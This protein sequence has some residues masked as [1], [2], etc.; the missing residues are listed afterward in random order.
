MKKLLIL[1][2]ALLSVAILYGAEKTDTEKRNL[3]GKVKSVELKAQPKTSIP[4]KNG[5]NELVRGN[6]KEIEETNVCAGKT[7][8]NNFLFNEK[9]QITGMELTSLNGNVK[10]SIKMEYNTD[11]TISQRTFNKR[12][13]NDSQNLLGPKNE[14]NE[15]SIDEQPFRKNIDLSSREGGDGTEITTYFYKNGKLFKT[16][17]EI[18]PNTH[19]E[20]LYYPNGDI[21]KITEKRGK[22]IKES[23]YNSNKELVSEK[24]NGENMLTQNFEDEYDDDPEGCGNGQKKYD[25]QGRLILDTAGGCNDN[26]YKYNSFNFLTYNH[27][28]SRWTENQITTYTGYLYDKQNNWTKRTVKKTGGYFGKT[29]LTITTTRKI[30]YF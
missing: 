25:T 2:L 13:I 6:V 4:K 11:G 9:K 22:D 10:I 5:M 14:I 29:G 28:S 27:N 24:Y 21:N 18:Q 17:I 3:Q 16:L 15:V 23:I 1:S 26:I 19:I 20:T 8:K 7:T 12:T 30:I